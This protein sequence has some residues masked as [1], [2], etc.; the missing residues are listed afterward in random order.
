MKNYIPIVSPMGAPP[1][2][3]VELVPR[4]CWMS[5]VRSLMSEWSWRKLR[6]EVAEDSGSR[7]EI[8][9]GRGRRYPVECHEVWWYDDDRQVQKLLRLQALCPMCHYVKHL[10][11][12]IHR[13][14]GEQ[15]CA[16]L[17]RVNGWDATTTERYVEAVFR[18]WGQRSRVDW[19]LDLQVLGDAYE[20]SLEQLGIQSYVLFPAQR[21]LMVHGRDVSTE[22]GFDRSGNPVA[23]APDTARTAGQGPGDLR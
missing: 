9:A 8:C 11:R 5:N 1:R 16:W 14:Y 4:T 15:A 13:G 19:L 23:Y 12:S 10:G 3:R 18:Q 6:T 20:I 22:D 2:L 21:R 17:A 7:C